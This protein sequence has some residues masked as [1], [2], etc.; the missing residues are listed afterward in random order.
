MLPWFLAEGTPK[1]FLILPTVASSLIVI[2]S[3]PSRYSLEP[4]V[5]IMEP[6]MVQ[7]SSITPLLLSSVLT[8][9]ITSFKNGIF[10]FAR[11]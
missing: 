2:D 11:I 8:K 1:I 3:F 10:S 7:D 9:D 5:T 4:L 6:S